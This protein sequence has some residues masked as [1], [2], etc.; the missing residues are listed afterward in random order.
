M[1][2]GFKAP[3]P[4]SKYVSH[5]DCQLGIGLKL[6]PLCDTVVLMVVNFSEEQLSV[7]KETVLDVAQELSEFLV[8]PTDEEESSVN[9]S[10]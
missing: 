4:V 6:R 5:I 10:E 1:P 7:P 3:T 2:V 9:G 8:V